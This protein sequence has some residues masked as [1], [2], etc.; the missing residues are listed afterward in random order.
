M[1]WKM[2]LVIGVLVTF[3]SGGTHVYAQGEPVAPLPVDTIMVTEDASRVVPERTSEF[4][5][6]KGEWKSESRCTMNGKE[7]SCDDIS[8]AA[9]SG[10]R[11]AY[12]LVGFFVFLGLSLFV[13]WIW[14]F[15]HALSNPID[16]KVVWVLCFIVFGV[17]T[18]IIYY[19]VVK[20]T[21]GARVKAAR[22]AY[23][24]PPTP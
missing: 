9:K 15:V 3:L 8:D 22:A 21:Y 16:N 14:M 10:M 23:T 1:N 6:G 18:A 20:R 19:F 24:P 17:V 13:L 12:A 7:V 11:F 4:E 2:F 5:A